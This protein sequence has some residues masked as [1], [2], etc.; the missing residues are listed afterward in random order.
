MWFDAHGALASLKAEH[1]RRP[2]ATI[3]TSATR[4]PLP[5][6][7]LPRVA[8]VAEVA[9]PRA[10]TPNR[11]AEALDAFEERAALREFDGG[12]PRAEAEHDA[13]HETAAAFSISAEVLSRQLRTG[14]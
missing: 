10:L 3:A 8:E 13:L 9:A 6:R 12:Q 2:P 7:K 4:T 5:A 14:D 11:L 1:G